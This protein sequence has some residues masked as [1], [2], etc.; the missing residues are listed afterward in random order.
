MLPLLF[1]IIFEVLANAVRKGEKKYKDSER[2]ES[3]LCSQV[4]GMLHG[5]HK[6][7]TEKP[8]LELI[9]IIARL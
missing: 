3:C 2:R 5:D 9:C 1:H 7:S 6:E 4:T 8:L